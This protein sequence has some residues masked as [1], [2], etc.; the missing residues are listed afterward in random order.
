MI[1]LDENGI[2]DAELDP[3]LQKPGVGDEE[4]VA[5]Q[6]HVAPHLVRHRLPAV[7]VVFG[8]TVFN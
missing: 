8:H 2:G 1:D 4:I 7:P 6:L 3:L 5:D